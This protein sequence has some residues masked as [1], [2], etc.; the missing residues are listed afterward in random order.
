MAVFKPQ[1]IFA[2]RYQLQKLLGLG[3]FSEVWQVSDQMAENTVV[4]LKIYAAGAGL[5]EDGIELFR[6]EYSLT[7]PL[8]HKSLLKPTYFDIAEGSPYLVMPLCAK[9]SLTKKLFREGTLPEAQLAVMMSNISDGLAYL[10]QR[11]PVVLHQDIKPDNVLITAKDDF[12]LSDFGI[13][14]RM[15]HTMMRSTRSTAS[16][17]SLTIAYAPPEKFT[18]R[19]R[20]MPASDVFSFGVMLYELC[21]NE[22]PWMGHRRAIVAY[23]FGST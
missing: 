5:D 2:G 8:N 11:A 20:S 19:P 9:G 17:N 10:H 23:W 14:S 12:L 18:S 15:R 13:S 4:A 6:R 1:D 7:L 21:T 16:S 3:G 22:V